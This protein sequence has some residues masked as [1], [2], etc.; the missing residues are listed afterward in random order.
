[1]N[2]NGSYKNPLFALYKDMVPKPNQNF[3]EQGQVPTSNYYQGGMPNQVTAQNYGGR[4][5]YNHSAAD[6]F[7]FRASGTTFHEYNVDWTYETEVRRAARQR[8]DARLVVVHRQLDARSRKSMVIDTPGLGQPLLPGSAAA[9]TARVQAHRRRPADVPRR[10]LP[11]ARAT[12]CC[13]PSTS[14]GIKACRPMP[15]AVW[16]PPISRR[17]AA[18][19]TSWARTRCAAASTTAWRMRKAGLMT[20]GNVSSTYTFDNLYTRAADTTSVFPASNIGLGLAA[21]M[22][23]IPTHG[24]DRPERADLR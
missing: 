14:P 15:T 21:L 24:V 6:R 9:G 2:P 20:A 3:V 12:A 16:R 8:Q 10:V 4:I 18:S 22:L 23:G 1:M 5:D 17:R 11:G 7:F 13:R 19:R